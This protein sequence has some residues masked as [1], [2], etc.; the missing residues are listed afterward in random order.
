MLLA[1]GKSQNSG[2][3]A[4][5]GEVHCIPSE[6]VTLEAPMDGLYVIVMIV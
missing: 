6:Y 3:C 5:D 4:S 1:I 2:E